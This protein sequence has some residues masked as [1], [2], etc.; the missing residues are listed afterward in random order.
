[1]SVPEKIYYRPGDLIADIRARTMPGMS[2]HATARQMAARY[3]RICAKSMPTLPDDGWDAVLRASAIADPWQPEA[4]MQLLR[5]GHEATIAEIFALTP[6]EA[7]ACRD[8][9]ER[10]RASA[11]AG[12]ELWRPGAAS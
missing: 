6:A 7:E 10:C 2:P 9:A 4:I 3:V 12:E 8:W 5:G 11:A 1:M